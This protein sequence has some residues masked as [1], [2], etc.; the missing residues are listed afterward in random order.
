MDVC[1]VWG[2]LIL[3]LPQLVVGRVFGV[4]PARI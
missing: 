4:K 1:V 2:L 3:Q